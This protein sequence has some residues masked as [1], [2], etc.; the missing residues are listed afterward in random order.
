MGV[1]IATIAIITI[2]RCSLFVSW[3]SG[4][5]NASTEKN[6]AESVV[7]KHNQPFD[8]ERKLDALDKTFDRRRNVRRTVMQNITDRYKKETIK[9][10]L[11]EP[12]A[13]CFTDERFG[14]NERYKA[15]GDGM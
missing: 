9:F 7:M 15:F 10:D 12:E 5:K 1:A 8:C 3:S 4:Y 6:S 14:S 2:Q 11:Y 13:V